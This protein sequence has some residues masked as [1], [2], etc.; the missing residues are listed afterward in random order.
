MTMNV[1]RRILA[2]DRGVFDF[3]PP[4][5]SLALFHERA[6][7]FHKTTDSIPIRG[8]LPTYRGVPLILVVDGEVW[9]SVRSVISMFK[10][11]PIYVGGLYEVRWGGGVAETGGVPAGGWL[12]LTWAAGRFPCKVVF[13]GGLD[14]ARARFL[15]LDGQK[16]MHVHL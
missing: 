9:H 2:A 1:R 14:P 3:R 8:G 10:R 12:G 11:R 5:P 15:I 6:A 16:V 7:G 4:V 13:Q